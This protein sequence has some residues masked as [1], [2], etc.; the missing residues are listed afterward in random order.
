M[1]VHIKTPTKPQTNSG[2]IKQT[3]KKFDIQ[4]VNCN[5]AYVLG[6]SDNLQ[7]NIIAVDGIDMSQDDVITIST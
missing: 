6:L 3:I 2:H 7:N 4:L 1:F 5:H